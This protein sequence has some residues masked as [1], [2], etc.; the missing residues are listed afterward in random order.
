MFPLIWVVCLALGIAMICIGQITNRVGNLTGGVVLTLA[1]GALT[2]TWL[3]LYVQSCMI[4][5]D[6]KTFNEVQNDNYK[7]MAKESGKAIDW[8]NISESTWYAQNVILKEYALV[9]G[10]FAEGIQEYNQELGRLRDFNENSWLDLIFRDVP[11]EL[12]FI[13]LRVPEGNR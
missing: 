2:V 10:G 4:V 9:L 13:K 5:A 6:L 3:G 1:F 12:E 11:P 8:S 7:R